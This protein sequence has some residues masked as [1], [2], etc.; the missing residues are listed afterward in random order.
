MHGESCKCVHRS[1]DNSERFARADCGSLSQR[2]DFVQNAHRYFEEQRQGGFFSMHL[3]GKKRVF[4]KAVAKVFANCFMSLYS[5]GLR[6]YMRQ[7]KD[8]NGGT[9][10]VE[11]DET[12][13]EFQSMYVPLD[14]CK[15]FF[16]TIFRTPVYG[17]LSRKPEQAR[18]DNRDGQAA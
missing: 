10:E 11:V 8:A 18:G 12:S 2:Y 13:G 3:A 14:V 17:L 15:T 7:L 16:D 5:L 1:E 6:D 9:V 4:F